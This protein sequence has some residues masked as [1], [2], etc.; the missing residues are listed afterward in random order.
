MW[1]V[2]TLGKAIIVGMLASLV[3]II[4]LFFF[5]DNR[6]LGVESEAHNAT[7]QEIEGFHPSHMCF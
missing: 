7:C 2:S 3:P 5:N 1:K 4:S 6:S